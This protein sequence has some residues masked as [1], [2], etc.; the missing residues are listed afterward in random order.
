[1]IPETMIDISIPSEDAYELY[2]DAGGTL[3]YATFFVEHQRLLLSYDSGR[4][5]PSKTIGKKEEVIHTKVIITK[6]C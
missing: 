1:M 3:N 6:R 4:P 2:K 5:I